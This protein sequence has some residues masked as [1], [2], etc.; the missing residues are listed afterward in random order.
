[1][2][3]VVPAQFISDQASGANPSRRLLAIDL[4]K[5]LAII[6]VI[7][8]HTVSLHVL[9]QTA[10]L[11]HIWQAVPVFMCLMG[12][13]GISSLRRRG[14]HSLRDLYSRDYFAARFDRIIIP[15]L[16]AF[17]CTA[18]VAGLTHRSHYDAFMFLG[19]LPIGGPGGNYFI[20]L[21]IQYALL[22][23]LIY[24]GLRRWPKRALLL[25]LAIDI[26]FEIAAP[27]IA[28]FHSHPYLYSV[29]SL[30]FLFLVGLG[31]VI[32]GLSTSQLLSSWWLW[33]GA[34]LSTAYL[35]LIYADGHVVLFGEAAYRG[36]I[37]L[38]DF[39]PLLMVVLGMRLLPSVARG[40]FTRGIAELGRASYH[41][42]L[43]QII[44]FGALM[45]A[46]GSWAALLPN[47]A[48]TLTVGLIF[49][50]LT[51]SMPLPST[52]KNLRPPRPASADT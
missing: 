1:M 2:S 39:Y 10:A 15:F 36:Q 7:I 30:R 34:L 32:A 49:Y 14:M 21:V 8:L 40:R 43:V 25:C 46:A 20:A 26:S 28:L 3:T 33:A 29:C 19:E 45:W 4:I 17:A 50:R 47:L 37:F 51:I 48:A 38:I 44:W 12:L 13:N 31:G 16:L 27:R 52:R 24:W 35:G 9:Y 41:I 6:S 18:L 5:G 23:P 22:I 42:F 11:F